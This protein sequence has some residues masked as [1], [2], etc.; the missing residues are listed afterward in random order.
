MEEDVDKRAM[1]RGETNLQIISQA[2]LK[3]LLVRIF[4]FLYNEIQAI[5]VI[6][7]T[8]KMLLVDFLFYDGAYLFVNI[9]SSVG[10]ESRIEREGDET[11]ISCTICKRLFEPKSLPLIVKPDASGNNY[12]TESQNFGCHKDVL[13]FCHPPDVIAIYER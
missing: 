9:P 11:R 1:I 13:Q 7:R 12:Q 4:H 6:E 8:R 10:K 5:P 2:K 3:H